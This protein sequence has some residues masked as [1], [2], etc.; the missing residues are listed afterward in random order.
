MEENSTNVY[1]ANNREVEDFLIGVEPKYNASVAKLRD[2]RMDQECI[3]AIAGF[4]A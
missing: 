4:A 2:Q 3:A 1:L